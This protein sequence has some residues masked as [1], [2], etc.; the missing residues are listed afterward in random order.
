M[1]K[2][3]WQAADESEMLTLGLTLCKGFSTNS[4]GVVYLH[5]TLGM[6]K[7]TLSRAI[8]QGFGWQGPV[9]SPTYTLVETYP[10]KNFEINHFDLYRISDP[11][12]LEY[13]GIEDFFSNSSLN[14]IEWPDNGS[15]YLPRPDLIIDFEE[16]GTGR[17]ITLNPQNDKGSEW[18]RACK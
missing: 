12:E 8:V 6:G 11:E 16:M 7:T 13:I 1:T 18:C 10:F 15:G 4:S 2:Y 17:M 9:K 14:L 5:G 3:Q